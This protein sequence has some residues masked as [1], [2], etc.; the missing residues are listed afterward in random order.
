MEI[1]IIAPSQRAIDDAKA[2]GV[3][4]LAELARL[5]YFAIEDG[6]NG[7]ETG[8]I[9]IRFTEEENERMSA[10]GIDIAG[11]I[12]SIYRDEAQKYLDHKMVDGAKKVID[13][14]DEFGT[15]AF[16]DLDN[17]DVTK[18]IAELIDNNGCDKLVFGASL[19]SMFQQHHD[20]SAVSNSAYSPMK[21]IY[22]IGKYNDTEILIDPY[23]IWSDH[24]IY[25]I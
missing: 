20:F 17:V 22:P 12:A 16:M 10:M 13:L 18:R 2:R 3:D 4:L 21:S 15:N 11:Q 23:M 24:K 9:D 6:L 19:G 8:Y 1:K 7:N 14:D 25:F 5:C